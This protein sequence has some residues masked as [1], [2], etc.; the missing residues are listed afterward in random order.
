MFLND[1]HTSSVHLELFPNFLYHL[2]LCKPL[3]HGIVGGVMIREKSAYMI[4]ESLLS[5]VDWM[6]THSTLMYAGLTVLT[7]LTLEGTSIPKFNQIM[8]GVLLEK[9]NEYTRS[10]MLLW[11][12]QRQPNSFETN[13]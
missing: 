6:H 7:Y 2:I 11:A 10:A 13:F 9:Q 1:P 5:R 12:F 3:L 4:L 8:T